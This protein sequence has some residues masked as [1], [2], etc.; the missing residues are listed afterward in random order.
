MS[1]SEETEF[2]AVSVLESLIEAQVLE[3]VLTEENI[4]HEIRSF[5]DTAYDGLF[6][7]QKGWGQVLAPASRKADVRDLI[8]AIRSGDGPFSKNTT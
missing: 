2:V 7:T 4:P 1:S 5:H 3:G 6:Q 8:N